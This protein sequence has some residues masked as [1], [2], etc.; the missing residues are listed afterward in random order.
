MEGELKQEMKR[1]RILVLTL[2]FGWGHVRAARTIATELLAQAPNAEV[3]V[4]DALASPR[5]LFHAGYVWP[6]WAMLRYA[7]ALWDWFFNRRLTRK[8]RRTAPGWAFRFGCPQVFEAIRDFQPDTIVATEVAACEMAA[9]AKRRGLTDARILNV[10]TDYESEPVWVQP[11]VD[12]YAVGDK[13]VADQLAAWGAAP[14]KISVC[15]IPTAPSFLVPHDARSTRAK[16]ELSAIAPVV[17]IMGGGMGPTHMDEVAAALL[18]SGTPMQIVAITGHDARARRRLERLQSVP[19]TPLHALGWTDDVPSLMQLASVLI[20]KPGGLTISEAAVSALPL[21]M[22]DAIPGPEYRNAQRIA[23]TGAG[24]LTNS[25]R[26]AAV[27]TLSLLRDETARQR[28]SASAKK[29]AQ[30]DAAKTIARLALNESMPNVARKM[31]A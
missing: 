18:E 21:V 20:T 27:V 3:C 11:E 17:L 30:P 9:S 1:P 14:E 26:E 24:V 19:L 6:Y 22:F 31:T 15:G 23:A 2:S 8:H 29:L 16:Y 10:L 7:P 28:M 5:F 4:V 12:R 25:A 13:Y